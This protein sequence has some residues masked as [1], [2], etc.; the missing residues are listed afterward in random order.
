MNV[1]KRSLLYRD[2]GERGIITARCSGRGFCYRDVKAGIVIQY[3]P[4]QLS[5][6]YPVYG[7][8]RRRLGRNLITDTALLA[9]S[10]MPFFHVSAHICRTERAFTDT[11]LAN[12]FTDCNSTTVGA[13]ECRI[14]VIRVGRACAANDTRSP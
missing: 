10:G 4:I 6:S 9:L 11:T 2:D 8:A 14:S 7:H 1:L 12:D 3:T 13:P 5:E